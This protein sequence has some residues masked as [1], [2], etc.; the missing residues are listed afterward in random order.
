MNRVVDKSIQPISVLD[1]ESEAYLA[2]ILSNKIQNNLLKEP[3]FELDFV[4]D[5]TKYDDKIGYI[6]NGNN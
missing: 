1:F 4:T 5:I 6:S 2:D 3:E